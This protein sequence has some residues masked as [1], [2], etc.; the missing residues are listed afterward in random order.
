MEERLLERRR[1]AARRTSER[2]PAPVG[3]SRVRPRR[4]RRRPAGL[5]T[6]GHWSHRP[7]AERPPVPQV[8]VLVVAVVRVW[9]FWSIV[10]I[11]IRVVV[12]IG[13]THRPFF[14]WELIFDGP[15]RR[16][17]V[18]VEEAARIIILVVLLRRHGP[19][20]VV[21]AA[22][23]RSTV[24]STSRRG[25][26]RVRR[27][28]SRVVGTTT[29]RTHVRAHH[30]YG[31]LGLLR[32]DGR[33]CLCLGNG[34]HRLLGR[35]LPTT[36]RIELGLLP[37]RG[38]GPALVLRGLG[39]PAAALEGRGAAARRIAGVVLGLVGHGCPSVTYYV[40]FDSVSIIIGAAPG[41]QSCGQCLLEL[42]CGSARAGIFKYA[43]SPRGAAPS[44]GDRLSAAASYLACRHTSFAAV[45]LDV[46]SSDIRACR[47]AAATGVLQRNRTE[48]SS[49][50][51]RRAPKLEAV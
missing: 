48:A 9:A 45:L 4:R 41:R 20:R 23:G 40:S 11:L 51:A 42:V 37:L 19:F 33:C 3:A 13:R 17:R 34:R 47:H 39:R 5:G 1:V 49:M 24:I 32:R 25:S 2:A 46:G 22:T 16:R 8:L 35:G 38:L 21:R 15:R 29:R 36:F 43:T 12:I 44:R 27:T 10:V 7:E 18:R 26:E 14:K 30:S 6:L 31:E 50:P 28:R